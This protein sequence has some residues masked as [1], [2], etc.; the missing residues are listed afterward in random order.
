MVS[1]RV[2]KHGVMPFG[3]RASLTRDALTLATNSRD[4]RLAARP[5]CILFGIA[6]ERGAFLLLTPPWRTA[7]WCDSLLRQAHR[8]KSA[9]L[10]KRAEDYLG[11]SNVT[12]G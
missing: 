11:V 7:L 6:H 3:G 2:T 5:T 9:V 10:R 4:P 1:S 8:M 12:S